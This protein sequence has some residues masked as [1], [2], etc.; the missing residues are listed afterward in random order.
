MDTLSKN[1]LSFPPVSTT[2]LEKKWIYL[3]APTKNS[4]LLVSTNKKFGFTCQHQLKIR[5]YLSAPTKVDS[6]KKLY[7]INGQQKLNEP[8]RPVRKSTTGI[9]I[10]A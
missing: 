10:M 4:D 3:S 5:I 6:L 1:Q 7:L 2:F 8:A 9:I